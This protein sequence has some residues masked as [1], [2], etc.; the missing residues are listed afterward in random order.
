MSFPRGEKARKI[1]VILSQ[2]TYRVVLVLGE[3]YCQVKNKLVNS[4]HHHFG[5]KGK[6]TNEKKRFTQR[7]RHQLTGGLL[8]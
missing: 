4:F 5:K 2:Q 8:R 1:Q 6:N 3:V 7:R